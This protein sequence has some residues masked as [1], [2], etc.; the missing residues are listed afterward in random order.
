ML[1]GRTSSETRLIVTQKDETKE[2]CH[3]DYEDL[4]F[5]FNTTTRTKHPLYFF[6]AFFFLFISLA[7]S[8]LLFWVTVSR[9]WPH[10]VKGEGLDHCYDCA[11]EICILSFSFLP[12]PSLLEYCRHFA[13]LFETCA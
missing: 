13:K 12:C 5:Y 4:M 6:L 11:G 10:N 8:F 1:L 3:K 9:Y 7:Y 2:Y